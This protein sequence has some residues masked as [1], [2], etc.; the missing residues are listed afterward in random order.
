MIR[1]Q[2]SVRYFVMLALMAGTTCWAFGQKRIDVS[3]TKEIL[4]TSL[5]PSEAV[6][7]LQKGDE[8]LLISDQ[9][10]IAKLVSLFNGNIQHQVHACGYH[11]RLTFYRD[12][13]P[14][15]EIFFN[16]NCEKFDR[17]NEAICEIVQS[18]FRET[19]KQPNGYL[20]SLNIEVKTDP[21]TAV[22]DL[23]KPNHRV[24][25]LRP[26]NR[27]PYVEISAAATSRIPSDRSLWESEKTEATRNAE[28]LLADDIVRIRQR[29]KVVEASRFDQGMSVFGGG[30]ITEQRRVK[31]YFDVGTDLSKMGTLLA[32]SKIE[33][34]VV[35]ET[36]S[37]QILTAKRLT[38][39]DIE[40]LKS[41]FPF[42]RSIESY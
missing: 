38:D 24:L 8:A 27:L 25:R 40:K 42:V 16:E 6:E 39:S 33:A 2:Q 5:R 7:G 36:Y 18:K 35:P 1:G 15:T 20:S 4:I 29:Y 37:L 17:N 22:S 28:R 31:V 13:G 9:A 34:T 10:Q 32:N 30:E 23:L 12:G 41:D 3:G 19:V 14:L 11:W 21:E 26:I